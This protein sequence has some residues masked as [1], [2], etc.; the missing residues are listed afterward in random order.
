MISK[1]NRY[2]QFI[3]FTTILNKWL[4]RFKITG[5][6]QHH[7]MPS[8]L[9]RASKSIGPGARYHHW[10]PFP[11]NHFDKSIIFYDW[12][13]LHIPGFASLRSL[14]ANE[15]L[16]PQ[17]SQ[18]PDPKSRVAFLGMAQGMG[19]FV[20]DLMMA[21]VVTMVWSHYH[22]VS[23]YMVLYGTRHLSQPHEKN[24]RHHFLDDSCQIRN[25]LPSPFA[26]NMNSTSHWTKHFVSSPTIVTLT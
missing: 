5:T 14:K 23:W 18:Y 7:S 15:A 13:S 3:S 12:F 22:A 21:Y 25:L 1:S 26:I 19:W 6:F 2:H 4:L 17:A 8:Q 10:F 16:P 24:T 20:I 11:S 9:Q